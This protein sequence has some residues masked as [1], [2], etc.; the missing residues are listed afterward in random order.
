VTRWEAP[1]T[2]LVITARA[3]RADWRLDATHD[4][5]LFDISV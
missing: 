1:E 3:E 5:D 2:R 4:E